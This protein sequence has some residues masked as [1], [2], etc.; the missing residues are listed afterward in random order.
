LG[1]DEEAAPG[2]LFMVMAGF[3]VYKSLVS[4]LQSD[5][6]LLGVAR[7]RFRIDYAK[8]GRFGG[9][10]R[11]YSQTCATGSEQPMSSCNKWTRHGLSYSKN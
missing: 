10:A 2:R 5:Q 1:F 8:A 4:I 7:I 6:R 11:S 9:N 3:V